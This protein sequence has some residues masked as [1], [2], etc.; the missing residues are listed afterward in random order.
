MRT[1]YIPAFILMMLSACGQSPE[2]EKAAIK[3]DSAPKESTAIFVKMSSAVCNC[4]STSMRNNKPSLTI[5][6]CYQKVIEQY[7][8]SLKLAGVDP[9]TSDGQSKLSHE[10]MGKFNLHCP[11]ISRLFQIETDEANAKKLLFKGSFISQRILAT[12]EYEIIFS[13]SKTY[14]Q[15]I[16]K[17]KNSFNESSVKDLLPGYEV[18]IEYEMKKNT[19]TNKDEYYIKENG[20]IMTVGAVPV[21][22]QK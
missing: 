13:D 6:S 20:T 9:A 1:L 10:I 5:D 3:T 12:G 11:E 15:K 4:T 7:T 17:S 16:F 2:R 19:K 21:K 8:D 14:E 22:T 18:T